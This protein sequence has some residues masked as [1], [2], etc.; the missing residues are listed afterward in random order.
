MDDYMNLSQ[1]KGET[2]LTTLS[3]TNIDLRNASHILNSEFEG[4]HTI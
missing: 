2:A 3:A 4:I 1:Q